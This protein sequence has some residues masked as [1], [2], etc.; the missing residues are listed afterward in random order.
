MVLKTPARPARAPAGRKAVR[1]RKPAK[2]LATTAKPAATT[3][4]APKTKAALTATKKKTSA[5]RT[6]ANARTPQ[7]EGARSIEQ[8]ILGEAA[9]APVAVLLERVSGAIEDELNQIES[10]VSGRLV[11]L[12]QNGHAER[13]ARMLASLARTLREVMQLRAGE[14]KA[15]RDDDAVP[16]DINELRR[17]LASRLERIVAET[18]PRH[19]GA[20]E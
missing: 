3:T 20:T 18:A 1:V 15:Q 12:R 4:K 8:K 11:P 13:R 7:M 2:K 5:A 16:R 9:R 17:E 10:M 14:E 19:S 6:R